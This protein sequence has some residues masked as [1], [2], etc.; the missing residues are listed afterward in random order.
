MTERFKDTEVLQKCVLSYIYNDVKHP[1]GT[2]SKEFI[3][4]KMMIGYIFDL[5]K[6]AIDKLSK[7]AP[8]INDTFIPGIDLEL[9]GYYVAF[10]RLPYLISSRVADP[11]RDDINDILAQFGMEEYD[12]FE[13]FMRNHGRSVDSLWVDKVDLDND[14]FKSQYKKMA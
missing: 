10:Q 14:Y 2:I 9:D 3:K 4:D 8:Y 1:I 7:V 13:M 6:K 12:A 5:D 11:R